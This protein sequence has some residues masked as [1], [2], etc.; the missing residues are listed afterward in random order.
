MSH[1]SLKIGKTQ[2]SD[3]EQ[4][5]S[6]NMKDTFDK[7]CKLIG[8]PR[9]YGPTPEEKAEI[10]RIAQEEKVVNISLILCS[11]VLGL[12]LFCHVSPPFSAIVNYRRK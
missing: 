9:N 2:S 10:E 7:L 3:I 12:G 1:I 5:K 11:V 8:K 4:D 6:L